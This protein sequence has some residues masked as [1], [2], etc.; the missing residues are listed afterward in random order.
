MRLRGPTKTKEE[1]EEA[2]NTIRKFLRAVV[3]KANGVMVASDYDWSEEHATTRR[4]GNWEFA[5]ID[6][7]NLFQKTFLSVP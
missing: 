1:E 6:S 2:I 3:A 7:T 5:W 4:F